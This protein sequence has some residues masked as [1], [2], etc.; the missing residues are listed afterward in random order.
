MHVL[1]DLIVVII[2]QYI[3]ISY[4]LYNLDTISFVNFMSIKLEKSISVN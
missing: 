2:S 3:Q 1:T 4:I